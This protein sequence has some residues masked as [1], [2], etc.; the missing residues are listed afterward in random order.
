MKR[1]SFLQAA[2]PFAGILLFLLYPRQAAEG[3][4]S[5]LQF[6]AQVL[7]PSLF[8]ISVLAGCFVRMD[9]VFKVGKRT[10]RWMKRF[11]G[12]SGVCAVP[13]FLGLI[14]G[15]PLGAQL[16]SDLYH[17]ERISEDEAICLAA[18]CN[19]PGPAY[20]F[21]AVSVTVGSQN[22]GLLLWGIQ[23][24]SAVL[25]A[26]LLKNHK[27][28][29]S[30]KPIYSGKQSSFATLLPASIRSS[31]L[32]M[33][34]MTGSVCFFQAFSACLF[35]ILPVHTIPIPMRAVISGSLEVSG[36][37][38]KLHGIKLRA[39]LPIAAFLLNW[40]GFCVHLQTAACFSAAGL[41]TKPYLKRKLLQLF[42]GFFLAIWYASVFLHFNPA[43]AILSLP[44]IVL[45]IFFAVLK[46]YR[47][48]KRFSVL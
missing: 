33:A 19:Q 37:I 40:N 6:C 12:L 5:G 25:T 7:I 2:A 26:L 17:R 38:A 27:P 11:F 20:L 13:I 1:I 24:L 39:A 47:W 16:T 31:V 48:K 9:D 29:L 4:R 22:L 36:G 10:D 42:F 30:T 44:M 18:L 41:P 21:G 34:V 8:P 35:S 3:V 15:F 14:G 32:N 46:K 23:L 43:A 28:A 45:F